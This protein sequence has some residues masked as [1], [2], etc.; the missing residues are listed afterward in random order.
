MFNNIFFREHLGTTTFN[1]TTCKKRGLLVT[2]QLS[3]KLFWKVKG[4]ASI[5]K[6]LFYDEILRLFSLLIALGKY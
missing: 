5:L 4:V 1:E 3:H 6:N 2:L